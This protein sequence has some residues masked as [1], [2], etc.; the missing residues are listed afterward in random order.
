[1]NSALRERRS[2]RDGYTRFTSVLPLVGTK[3]FATNGSAMRSDPTPRSDR[4]A[5]SGFVRQDDYSGSSSER[6]WSDSGGSSMQSMR[7]MSARARAM[8][9][10]SAGSVVTTKGR[11]CLG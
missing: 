10:V 9:E 6:I 2:L 11:R 8:V 5:G 1:M 7:P 4:P 3:F